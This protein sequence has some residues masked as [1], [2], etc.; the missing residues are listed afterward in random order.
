M[1][2]VCEAAEEVVDYLNASGQKTG[3]VKVRLYR[4]FSARHFLSVLPATVEKIAVLDRTKEPGSVGSLFIWTSI[5]RTAGKASP[6]SAAGTAWPARTPRPV[7]S[8]QL[9]KNLN[10]PIPKQ[11]SPS[12][13]RTT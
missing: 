11:A 2:S 7:R 12:V 9:S 5:P 8:L 10:P 6:L 1:G 3:L 13:L 4:P